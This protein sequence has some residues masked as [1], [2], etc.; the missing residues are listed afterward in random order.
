MK[1]SP[2]WLISKGRVEE[3]YRVV[4]KKKH[5][6]EF[7]AKQ[8]CEVVIDNQ[9]SLN[10][11]SKYD[12]NAKALIYFAAKSILRPKVQKYFQ[13]TFI[14]IWNLETTSNGHNLP[15]HILHNISF[16]LCDRFIELF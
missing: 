2:R 14:T 5:G 1:E 15:L 9:V 13:G 16:I 12:H 8:Y 7:P 6:I 4:F 10:I 11:L 3:A